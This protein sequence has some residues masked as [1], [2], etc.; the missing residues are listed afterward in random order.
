MLCFL[1]M[2]DG[3]SLCSSDWLPELGNS[4]AL[5]F[6]LGLLFKR[7]MSHIP[8]SLFSVVLEGMEVSLTHS[9]YVCGNLMRLSI[10]AFYVHGV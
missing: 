10:W 2:Q 7:P 4:P 5:A 1:F 8:S 9:C 3:F 6:V